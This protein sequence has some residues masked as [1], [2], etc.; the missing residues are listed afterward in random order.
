MFERIARSF[1]AAFVLLLVLAQ[2]PALGAY[3]AHFATTGVGHRVSH[4]HKAARRM[5]H[6][7]GAVV[8]GFRTGGEPVGSATVLL[9]NDA[10]ES[11]YDSLPAGRAEAFRFHASA[12]GVASLAH[13]YMS[14]GNAASAVVVGLYTDVDGHPGSSLGTGAAATSGP[15][16]WTTVPVTS[17]QLKSPGIY[18]LAVLGRG[19]VLRYRDRAHGACSSQTSAQ[20]AL[21]TLPPHWKAGSWYGGCPISAYV[22]NLVAAA[23]HVAYLAAELSESPPLASPTGAPA[24]AP[25]PEEPPSPPPP[26]P[27][28][29]VLPT[30]AG[31]A[32]E[33]RTLRASDGAW[34]GGPTSFAYQ[35]E[36]CNASGGDCSHLVGATGSSYKLKAGDVGQ[37]I[38][39]VVTASNAWG[40]G[41]ASSAASAL[42]SGASQSAPTNTGP[43]SISGAAVEGQT[44]GTSNGI[45]AGG[46]T[47]FVYQWEDCNASGAS[48]TAIAGATGNTRRL[49]SSD[50]GHTLRVVV[51]AIN[52]A[53]TGQATSGATGVVTPEQGQKG[54]TPT[55]CFATPEACG[56]PGPHNTGPDGEG[57]AKCASLTAS[58]SI[59]A[60]TSGQKIEGLNVTGNIT[61]AA[62]NVTINNVCVTDNGGAKEGSQAIRLESAANKTTISNST[63]R[64]ENE[65]TK[66]VDEALSNNYGGTGELAMNDYIYNCGECIHYAWTV[67][68]TYVLVN[69]MKD[70]DDHYEDWYFN[71]NTISADDDTMLNSYK[72]TA[73]LFG[74]TNNGSGGG[75]ENH[76]T[77]TNSLLAGGGAMLYPCGNASSVG[78]ST[79]TIKNNRFA[80]MKCAKKEHQI[81]AGE[82]GE[83]G[84]ECEN[85]EGTGG[86]WPRGGF[87]ELDAYLFTG[88]NQTWE[89]NFWDNNLQTVAP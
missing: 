49:V 86:F 50:V 10:V 30:I 58:G 46:P 83:G 63:I 11:Q 16:T 56:Y 65:S 36:D 3:R 84:W 61:V 25:A 59:V 74:N 70:T 54:G 20:G 31:A 17:S 12:S 28:N 43:P 19:G 39:V 7:T 89:G 37:T 79:M 81:P 8:H 9:G 45:W 2:S 5:R 35:W 69:G 6:K 52:A 13:I 40:T 62:S 73:V 71:N 66:S 51:K 38:R 75:C 27:V 82:Y 72:Q 87:F 15:G 64:G 33:G 1:F 57:A 42:V 60:G 18:W 23:P 21:R 22:T 55:N 47:S 53:G 41:A 14:A 24:P 4:R 26:R 85:D 80:R 77:V 48:C 44:L 68:K 34:T 32:S 67:N 76:I 29:T 78:S 88:A